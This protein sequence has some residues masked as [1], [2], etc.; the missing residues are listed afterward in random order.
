MQVK[1]FEAR[2]MKEALEMVKKHLGPEAI[3]LGARDNRKS[4]GL[5]GE[6]SVEITAAITDEVLQ[7]KKFTES[8]MVPQV[9]EKFQ[10]SPARVQKQVMED[11]VN[12]FTQENKPLRPT[13]R[14][15]Y[16]DID[17]Q[18]QEKEAQQMIAD[19]A[20]T[21]IR[22]AAQRAWNSMQAHGEWQEEMFEVDNTPVNR[23]TSPRNPERGQ[24]LSG[25]LSQ[26]TGF[27]KQGNSP[28]AAK[29]NPVNRQVAPSYAPAAS[30][31]SAP[32][33][34]A[35]SMQASD[36]YAL[37]MKQSEIVALKSELESLKQMISQ[38]QKIPQTLVTSHPGA[39][40][41]L[42][43]EFSSTFE[44]LTQAGV[45]A[46]I[47]AEMLGLAQS[48]MPPVRFKNKALVD[49]WVARY[50]LN[51]TEIVGDK[52]PAKVQ[53]FVGP[54]G[55]G[56]T[57][58]LV[59]L[60]AHAAIRENKKVVL[61]TADT[62]KVG[63]AD[64][65]RI[66]ANILNVPFAMVRRQSDW[67]YLLTQLNSYDLILCD[68]PGMKLKTMEEIQALRSLLPAEGIEKD[69][70]LV[71]PTTLKNEDLFEMGKRFKVCGFSDVIFT[72]LDESVQQGT[73]Y[74]FMRNF[75]VPLHSFGT[76]P[77]VP[78]DFEMATKERVLDL[79]FKL[80]KMKKLE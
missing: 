58:S 29:A 33:P 17:D 37:N 65:M 1:K 74:N 76:G 70:H 24:S 54:S 73:I 22:G 11:F 13:T 9:R 72:T 77:R 36:S 56:K 57:S 5:V 49:A 60:A 78:E 63:A 12:K 61:L 47:A 40:F 66:Y 31:S 75:S 51:S 48:Q 20:Q 21:R 23:S 4:F 45:T 41:G 71:L 14:T 10:N 52:K 18:E 8:R 55:S 3:I 38:F 44:K 32:S 50:I 16:I 26:M 59:K 25:R 46:E 79:I 80:S 62:H 2:T 64:Q 28:L 69:T 68:Y 19:A 15:R 53:L 39:D 27:G 42:S 30:K 43:Y 35:G 34:A 7:K 67:D 6:G